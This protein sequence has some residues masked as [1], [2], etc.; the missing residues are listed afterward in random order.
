MKR[1]D[2]LRRSPRSAAA[3]FAI[4][5]LGA[6]P[7]DAPTQRDGTPGRDAPADGPGQDGSRQDGLRRDGPR[8]DAPRRDGPSTPPDTM[9][10]DYGKCGPPIVPKNPKDAWALRATSAGF[11]GIT[12]QNIGGHSD[13]FLKS[14]NQRTRIG[15]RLDW[16]GTL[17]FFGKV[18]DPLSNVIDDNDTGRELQIALYDQKRKRQGCAHNASCPSTAGCGA[19]MTFLGWN[20]VQGGDECG[21][22][23]K[24]LSHGRQG[25]SLVL[26]TRPIQWNPDW[27]AT[28]C[29]QNSCGAQGLP[30]QVTYTTELR[31]LSDYL[32]E[33]ST[34]VTSQETI[35]HQATG[36]EWPT[37]YV[38]FGKNGDPDFCKLFDAS[39]KLIALTT[40]A[41]DDHLYYKIFNS[42]APWVAFQTNAEN[43]G[44]GLAMDQGVR[45]FMGYGGPKPPNAIHF[46][47]VRAV[48]TFGLGAG[49][50][51]RGRS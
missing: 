1:D 16:G 24:V 46:H 28:T 47:N 26:V 11:G 32:V 6:C 8:Q 42:P 41:P 29:V 3:L 45:S 19:K 20:P 9:A 35:S 22:G 34:Q 48:V 40:L 43:Y 38:S 51:V 21:H 10:P 36:Q 50:T 27:A 4:L 44:V 18:G 12:T 39:H 37:M 30:V 15:A 31:F 25:D 5:C 33:V 2:H 49:A 13:V 14:P 7:S 17:V 23:A